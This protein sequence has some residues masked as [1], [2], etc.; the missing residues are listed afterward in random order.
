MT[1]LN[2]G[3][4]YPFENISCT[5]EVVHIVAFQ[6]YQS[7]KINVYSGSKNMINN[8]N[9]VTCPFCICKMQ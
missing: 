3:V 6:T 8:N 9:N 5:K 2:F 4:N 7:S 1:V